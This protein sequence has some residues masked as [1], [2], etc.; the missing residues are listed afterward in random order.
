MLC[1][2]LKNVND[3]NN[4]KVLT[5]EKMVGWGWGVQYTKTFEKT[6]S[7]LR[8]YKTITPPPRADVLMY[9]STLYL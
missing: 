7:S 1:T 4:L 6:A 9:V 2:L 3:F 5:N 8:V